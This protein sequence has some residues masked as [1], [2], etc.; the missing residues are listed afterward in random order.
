M[1]RPPTDNRGTKSQNKKQAGREEEKA[2][3][4]VGD[5]EFGAQPG[6]QARQYNRADAEPPVVSR[7]KVASHAKGALSFRLLPSGQ[8]VNVR[9]AFAR[10]AECSEGHSKS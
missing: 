6:A 8:P 2:C 10:R 9:V 7:W 4:N 1:I 3:R 5:V